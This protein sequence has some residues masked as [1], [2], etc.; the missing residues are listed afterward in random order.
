MPSM[1]AEC[2]T[3]L[4]V[5]DEEPVLTAAAEMLRR[6]GFDVLMA[7]SPPEALTLCR[8]HPEPIHLALLDIVMPS[9]NGLELRE[10]LRTEYPG[11]RVLYMSE[12]NHQEM[13]WRG[14]TEIPGDF[15][16]KPLTSSKLV[17]KVNA[18]LWK[19]GLATA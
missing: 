15:L 13:A 6:A 12:Y 16:K 3:I 1:P 14:V 18:G 5:D 10:C 19:R 2:A 9:M 11:I 8:E 17:G 7:T 4:V